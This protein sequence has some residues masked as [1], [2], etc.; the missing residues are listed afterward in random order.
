MNNWFKLFFRALAA[1][2][3]MLYSVVALSAEEPNQGD[4][5]R[6]KT[7]AE[8]LKLQTDIAEQQAGLAEAETKNLILQ[9]KK[10]KTGLKIVAD[11]GNLDMD[12]PAK[13]EAANKNGMVVTFDPLPEDSVCVTKV[14]GPQSALTADVWF[15]GQL[16]RDSRTGAEIGSGLILS[17]IH[18]GDSSGWGITVK[19]PRI[20]KFIS[21]CDVY[22]AR[23]RGV[24]VMKKAF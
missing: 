2:V 21:M 1:C 16:M 6:M 14:G 20:N 23:S 17:M 24:P 4:I 22:A 8:Y 18:A 12:E 11:G 10:R 7:R 3:F 15:K 13:Q 9:E 5:E 19:G